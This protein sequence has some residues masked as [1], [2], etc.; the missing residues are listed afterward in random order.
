MLIFLL[1]A[2]IFKFFCKNSLYILD[3]NAL[4]IKHVEHI[5]PNILCDSFHI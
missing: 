5:L 3:S 4:S 2:Y 1:G